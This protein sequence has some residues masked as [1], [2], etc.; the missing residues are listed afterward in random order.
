MKRF[1]FLTS[2][3]I[4]TSACTNVTV[5]KFTESKLKETNSTNWGH[6]VNRPVTWGFNGINRSCSDNCSPTQSN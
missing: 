1:L 3:L 5:G 2:L 6:P 4:L